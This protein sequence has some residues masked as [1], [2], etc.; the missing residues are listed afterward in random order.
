MRQCICSVW[1]P[2]MRGN[3]I[4][5]MIEGNQNITLAQLSPRQE[6]EKGQL[7]SIL[8]VMTVGRLNDIE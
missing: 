7:N 5:V 3:G 8:V 1:Q 4:L 2:M 6:Y